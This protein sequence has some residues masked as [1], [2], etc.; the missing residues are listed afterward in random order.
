M[1]VVL[2]V[3]TAGCGVHL[4]TAPGRLPTLQGVAAVRDQA[5]RSDEAAASQARALSAK[6]GRCERCRAVLDALATDS[7]ARVAALGGA[8][9]P[10]GGATPAGAQSPAPVADA[11]MDPAE[12]ATW[13]A[14]TARRDLAAVSAD[15]DIDGDDARTIGAVAAGRLAGAHRLAAVYGVD[16]DASAVEVSTLWTR[17]SAQLEADGTVGGGWGQAPT[18]D[19][20]GAD[21]A[22][23]TDD[24][25]QSGAGPLVVDPTPSPLPSDNAE[26]T[27]SAELSSAVRTWDCVAQMLPR[28]QVVDRSVDDASERADALLA[29]AT[30]VLAMGVA[31][32]RVTRCRL[33]TSDVPELDQAVLGADL[34]LLTSSSRTVRS[35]GADLGAQDVATWVARGDKG[36]AA[37]PGTVAQK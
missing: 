2:A 32:T 1:A 17:L 8:W 25:A 12:L 9:D 26:V 24:D 15:T 22:D 18:A 29:R 3:S 37:V 36:L 6:A 27:A 21:P 28:A 19:A 34:D 16:L 33:D 5:V 7:D 11:P 20:T 4:S 30:S 13:L 35:I 23:S 31:D 10:W 14:A